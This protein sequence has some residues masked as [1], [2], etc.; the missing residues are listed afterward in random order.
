MKITFK[1]L[2][3]AYTFDKAKILLKRLSRSG[4]ITAGCA[5]SISKN[6]TQDPSEFMD[7]LVR[8]D[9]HIRHVNGSAII[10]HGYDDLEPLC[11]EDQEFNLHY[12]MTNKY[13]SD[14]WMQ[15][16]LV[17]LRTL[18]LLSNME[19]EKLTHLEMP[20][21]FCVNA[22]NQNKL[23]ELLSVLKKDKLVRFSFHIL[24]ECP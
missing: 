1:I 6:A 16:D 20:Y 24:Y 5:L 17:G 22:S 19:F 14:A 13:V 11:S 9:L 23:T 21:A 8:K 18:E 2:S 4:F 3:Y 12:Y 15:K 7:R 10:V